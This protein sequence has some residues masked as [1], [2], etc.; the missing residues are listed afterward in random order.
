MTAYTPRQLATSWDTFKI[1]LPKEFPSCQIDLRTQNSN[2]LKNK[3]EAR[4]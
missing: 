2:K 3:S 1:Y 4:K